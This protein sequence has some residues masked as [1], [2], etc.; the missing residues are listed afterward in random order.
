MSSFN[1]D[2]KLLCNSKLCHSVDFVVCFMHLYQLSVYL[3][4]M[5]FRTFLSV[6]SNKHNPSTYFT[7]LIAHD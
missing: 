1:V 7:V 5:Q 3:S 4:Y 2:V 6:F